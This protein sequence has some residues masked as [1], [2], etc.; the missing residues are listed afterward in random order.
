MTKERVPEY[1]WVA[2]GPVSS[3]Y[4][5]AKSKINQQ[6][7]T[8]PAFQE[9][10]HL[11][12]QKTKNYLSV[13]PRRLKGVQ[14]IPRHY[15]CK[16]GLKAACQA[17]S[18]QLDQGKA[19]LQAAEKVSPA[20]LSGLQCRSNLTLTSSAQNTHKAPCCAFRLDGLTGFRSRVYTRRGR[21]SAALVSFVPLFKRRERVVP[22]FTRG[23]EWTRVQS[24]PRYRPEPSLSHRSIL[25]GTSVWLVGRADPSLLVGHRFWPCGPLA[26][27]TDESGTNPA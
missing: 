2:V 11:R 3:R 26:T 5:G 22:S 9:Q 8:N 20:A 18:I 27:L 24:K 1:L 10:I 4:R 6:G 15:L 23:A 19:S 14:F 12:I 21:G 7:G 25:V 13:F 17:R 16:G